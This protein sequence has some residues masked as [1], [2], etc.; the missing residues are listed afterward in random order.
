MMK[1]H[2]L[3][4]S[5]SYVMFFIYSL[6]IEKLTVKLYDFCRTKGDIDGL[7]D[8]VA[9][10]F[11]TR[12]EGERVA[13]NPYRDNMTNEQIVKDGY[14]L[15]HSNKEQYVIDVYLRSTNIVPGTMWNSYEITCKKV[16]HFAVT[17]ASMGLPIEY[18]ENIVKKPVFENSHITQL[19]ADHMEELKSRLVLQRAQIEDEMNNMKQV[20]IINENEDESEEDEI[21]RKPPIA[22]LKEKIDLDELFQN[23]LKDLEEIVM[24]PSS[25]PVPP[26][27]PEW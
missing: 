14:F 5:C 6:D 10:N 2:N 16:M 26:P 22:I 12:E 9:R 20:S 18:K 15:R 4:K 27:R 17:E 1:S 3:K 13:E 8:T 11:I 24:K 25:V 7:L 23:S 21:L 19:Q